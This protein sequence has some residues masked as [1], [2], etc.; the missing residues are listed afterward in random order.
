LQQIIGHFHIGTH[1][2]RDVLVEY[3][4][5]IAENVRDSE[6]L[7]APP[8]HIRNR[9]HQLAALLHHRQSKSLR[10]LYCRG[11]FRDPMATRFGLIFETLPGRS[12]VPTTD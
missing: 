8:Q 6:A 4:N 10:L 2:Q 9:I 1:Q 7:E 5:F 12:A 11:F 3:K